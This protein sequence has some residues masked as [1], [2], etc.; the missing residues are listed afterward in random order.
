[1][2]D[3]RISTYNCCSL[4]T[5]I[6]VI[7]SIVDKKFDLIFLQEI[8]ITEDRLGDIAYIDDNYECRIAAI[9]S[10][11]SLKSYRERYEGG[12]V[13]SLCGEKIFI[14]R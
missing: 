1:M 13:C 11:K 2:M 6:E 14:I 4:R 9:Y 10:E 8:F 7:R 3:I 12:L 5:N